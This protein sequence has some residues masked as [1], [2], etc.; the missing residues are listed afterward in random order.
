MLRVLWTILHDFLAKSVL[1]KAFKNLR[2]LELAYQSPYY[3]DRAQ[4]F[5]DIADQCYCCLLVSQVLVVSFKYTKNSKR[6]FTNDGMSLQFGFQQISLVHFSAL[7]RFLSH[8]HIVMESGLHYSL[9]WNCYY[10]KIYK[11]S[12]MKYFIHFHKNGEICHYQKVINKNARKKI[13]EFLWVRRF[14]KIDVSDK[15]ID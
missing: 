4:V 8:S 7:I 3:S 2:K 11:N 15:C 9:L 12:I 13:K 14:T 1:N 10:N 5:Q 6:Y